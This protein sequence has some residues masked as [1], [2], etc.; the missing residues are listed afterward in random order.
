MEKGQIPIWDE[1]FEIDRIFEPKNEEDYVPNPDQEMI[2]LR[3]LPLY[4][5]ELNYTIKGK[6]LQ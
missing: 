1:D 4:K 3:V 6:C 2:N 5:Q